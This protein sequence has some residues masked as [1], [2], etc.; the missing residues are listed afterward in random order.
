MSTNVIP[1]ASLAA[2]QQIAR[3]LHP[4]GSHLGLDTVH[5]PVLDRA[6][7]LEVLCRHW[8]QTVDLFSAGPDCLDPD[9]AEELMQHLVAA[10][11]HPHMLPALCMQLPQLRA[12]VTQHDRIRDGDISP[13]EVG[14]NTLEQALAAARGELDYELCGFVH[15]WPARDACPVC[16]RVRPSVST[17][18]TRAGC[19]DHRRSL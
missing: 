10:V 8:E 18:Q 6:H 5:L 4:A 1:L 13:Y 15:G 16:V 3:Q 9:E 12:A 14:C 17:W 2:K 7:A 11:A 19:A